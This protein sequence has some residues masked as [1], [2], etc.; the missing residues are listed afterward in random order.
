MENLSYL[1][2]VINWKVMELSPGNLEPEPKS[3]T[4]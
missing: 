4:L 1:P 2:R 3:I